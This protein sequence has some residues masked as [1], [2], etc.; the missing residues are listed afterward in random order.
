MILNIFDSIHTKE[1][2]YP[3]NRIYS[4]MIIGVLCYVLLIILIKNLIYYLKISENYYW[5]LLLVVLLDIIMFIKKNGCELE[6]ILKN[7]LKK[8]TKKTI[9]TEEVKEDTPPIITPL[10]RETDEEYTSIIV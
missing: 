10:V 6:S 8:I 7:I 5:I 1:G 2:Q 3:E 4:I 9:K